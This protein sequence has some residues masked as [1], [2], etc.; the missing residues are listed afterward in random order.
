MAD[1]KKVSSF[2]LWLMTFCLLLGCNGGQEQ[3]R[4]LADLERRDSARESITN[5]SLAEAL[6]TYFDHHGSRN[7]RM[8]SKY[9]LGRTYFFLG[10]LP[11][12]LETLYEAADCAD[13]TAADCDFITLS[14]IHKQSASIFYE[15]VQP[16]SQLKEL[17]LAEYYAW[18]GGDT[19]K[20]INSFSLQASAYDYLKMH[21]SIIAVVEKATDWYQRIGRKDRA[22]QVLG[23]AISSLV[24]TGDTTKAKAYIKGYESSPEYFD[25]DG[26]IVANRVIY[27]YIKGGYYLAVNMLDSAEYLYRRELREGKDINNQV[28]GCKG[29][30]MVFEKRGNIDSIAKYANLGYILNDSAYSL[31]EMQNIQKLQASYNYNHNKQIAEESK[32]QAQRGWNAFLAILVFVILMAATVFYRFLHYKAKRDSELKD[33]LHNQHALEKAQSELLELREENANVSALIEKR[34]REIDRLQDVIKQYQ[35]RQSVKNAATLE[36]RLDESDIKRHLENLLKANPYQEATQE[37]F[38]RLKMLINEEIPSF[39]SILNSQGILRP[40]EYD[41]CILIRCHFYP[42][43]ICKLTGR[44]DSYIANIRKGVLLK[45]YGIKG[46][47]RDLDERLLTIK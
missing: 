30:Q 8:R 10:E 2:I 28:A 4:L 11:H 3:H 31:S 6:V 14:N 22:S 15:Q 5:D 40:I 9:I 18:K 32:L 24:E 42:A 37:D 17:R 7:E 20:A 43:A 25:K 19:L 39:Y 13:T 46:T 35:Q 34:S 36:T 47:P 38:K 26:N 1:M 12:A 21:D 23:L 29:L 45:V 44:S 27:Y 41:V 16:R 33:Y